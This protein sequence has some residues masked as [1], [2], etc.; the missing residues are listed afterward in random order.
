MCHLEQD[1]LDFRRIAP[2]RDAHR[3]FYTSV[4]VTE[5]PVGHLAGNQFGVGDNHV[6]AVKSLDQGRTNSDSSYI[7]F[8]ITNHDPVTGLD[9]TFKQQDQKPIPTDSAPAIIARLVKVTPAI[10]RDT[11][12]AMA[13]PP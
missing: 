12:K 9:R 4:F 13:A 5:H 7:T 11:S 6:G 1:L 2:I 3:H 8:R 10:L